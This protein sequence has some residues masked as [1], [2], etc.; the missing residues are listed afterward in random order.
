MDPELFERVIM[1]GGWYWTGTG[2]TAEECEAK[3][4]GTMEDL[5]DEVFRI[6]NVVPMDVAKLSALAEERDWDNLHPS[7]E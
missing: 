5:T 3:R 6:A 7:A 2:W 1:R 4:F